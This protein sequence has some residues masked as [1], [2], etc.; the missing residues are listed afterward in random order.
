MPNEVRSCNEPPG[1]RHFPAFA[2]FAEKNEIAG[3]GDADTLVEWRDFTS[4]E[5]AT[6]P[7]QDR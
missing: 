7:D 6:K 5:W 4:G 1:L 3:H 2:G